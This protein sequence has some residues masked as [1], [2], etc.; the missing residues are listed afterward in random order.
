MSAKLE[1]LSQN[2]EKHLGERIKTKKLAL[3]EITIEVAA[4]DYLG[5]MQTLRD[6]AELRFDEVA[7]LCGVDYSTYGSS[8]GKGTRQGPRFA[9]VVHLLSVANNQRVRVRVFAD[10]DDF[11]SVPSITGLWASANWFEREAFDLYGI[12]FP[13]HNDLRRILTDY[14]FIGH[15][16]RKDF[17]VS[18]Y[19][20]MR[21]D[22]DQRR[23]IYQPVTI[24]PRENTPRI[25]R[26][27]TYGD[28]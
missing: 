4:D 15:P 28:L 19:V 1:T 20:E 24:E 22:P 3:G 13:G 12:V 23:V 6:E 11:P 16:F 18:G 9:V 26:E 2:L 7:D 14:G 17:P 27:E 21:Y 5:V 25:V 10:S 8:N